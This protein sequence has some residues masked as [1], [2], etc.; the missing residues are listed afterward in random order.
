MIIIKDFLKIV[1]CFYEVITTE[2]QPDEFSRYILRRE[3]IDLCFQ[4]WGRY[5]LKL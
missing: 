2:N 1:K 3:S 5:C 4:Y